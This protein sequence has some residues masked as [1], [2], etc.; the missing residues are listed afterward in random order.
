MSSVPENA[1]SGCVGPSSEEAGKASAC[2]GCPN[3]QECAS[4]AG[5]KTEVD[6]A[7][8]EI[9]ER[10]KDVKHKVLILSGKGG[11]GKST[12]SSQLAWTLASHYGFHVGLLDIDI[13]GPSIAR[14]CGVENQEV[15]KSN[16]GWSPVYASP[17]LAVMS[18]AFML[19]SRNDAIIWRGPRKNG[20]I[21]QFL[22][23]VDWGSLDFL[24]VDAPPGTSDEHLSIVQY[25]L[26]SGGVDGAIMVTTPQEVSLL[27]VRKEISF[28][29]KT[30]VK[31]LGVVENMSGYVCPCC[32]HKSHIFPAV[33]G[34]AAKM[35]E[36]MNVQFF[37][38]I[39]LDPT[40]LQSCEEGACFV[41]KYH[42]SPAAQPLLDVVA[43]VLEA[44]P[45]IKSTFTSHIEEHGVPPTLKAYAE[46]AA[47]TAAAAAAAPASSSSTESASAMTDAPT[48]C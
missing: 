36:E 29:K 28:C 39:P 38:A 3:Q 37:G 1:N 19:T 26:G 34:G 22:S 2:A 35:S 31:V 24:L 46:A 20:L 43:K 47:A 12:F 11:V 4:G 32:S 45:E 13:C 23:D 15:R 21:K 8:E 44:S 7:M 30:H 5:R 18:I 40:L 14:M 41:Q 10:L 42:Q 9:R 25:L 6:P 17:N 27:D 16:F 33:T 48:G